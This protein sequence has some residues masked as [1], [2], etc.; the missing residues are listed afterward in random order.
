MARAGKEW[1]VKD[2]TKLLENPGF[3]VFTGY[4]GLKSEQITELRKRLGAENSRMKVIKNSLARLGAKKAKRED[5]ISLLDGPVAVVSSPEENINLAKALMDFS[6]ANPVFTISGGLIGSRI[7]NAEE[8][9]N[10]AKLPG[11]QA[12][13]GQVAC[14]LASPINGFVFGLKGII[15]SLA[16][17]L[18]NIEKSKA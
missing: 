8:I 10:F 2:L 4:R 1:V 3:L 15:Q 16:N 11:R 6:R 17:V 5:I 7:L 13:L 12:L 18:K 9:G 14:G